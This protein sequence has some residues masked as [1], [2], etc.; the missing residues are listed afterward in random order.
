MPWRYEEESASF[1]NLE[2]GDRL[3]PSEAEDLVDDLVERFQDDAED[4]IN[5]LL[6]EDPDVAAFERDLSER[7]RRLFIIL[8]ILGGG[9]AIYTSLRA[10]V[11]RQIQKQYLYLDRFA[12]Q[13]Y[14][15]VVP[16]GSAINR[17]KMYINSARGAYW[18][19]RTEAERQ[20]GMVE[21]KWLVIG[22][23]HSCSPC[24][25]AG[26]MGY[27]PI[28]TFGQPGSGIVLRS[29]TTVCAGLTSCRCKK[30]FR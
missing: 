14:E 5:N 27:Q 29:P 4:M 22:D 20:R 23:E 12:K 10:Q 18:L 21:E 25:E 17:A 7:V 26:G 9:V 24:M 13:V 28:G 15:G 19:T 11:E 8:A 2:T 16:S 30:R 3:T 1:I 6:D